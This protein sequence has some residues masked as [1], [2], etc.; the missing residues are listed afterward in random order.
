VLASALLG[1][2]PPS[3]PVRRL[4]RVAEVLGVNENQARVA[5]SRMVARGEVAAD[6]AGTYTL[7]GPLLERAGRL[8]TAR[9]GVVGRSDGSWHLVVVV[10][11]GDQ[12]ATRQARRRTLR[13]ARLGELRE[14]VWARPANLPLALDDAT[15]S[16]CLQLE[17]RPADPAALASSVFDLGG[18]ARRGRDL[19]AALRASDLDAPGALASGFVLDAAV[20]R[21]L[22]RD[23]LLPTELLPSAWPGER[24]RTSYDEFNRAFRARLAEV[25]RAASAVGR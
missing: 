3:L 12:A 16:A 15:G 13:A 9:R 6:G 4:V 1:E 21:H 25:H 8:T 18:W 23:P 5:L 19:D 7:A 2:D 17:A 10:A 22:Q 14:G 24:L 20:L 11:S